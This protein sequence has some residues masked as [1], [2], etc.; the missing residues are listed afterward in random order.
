VLPNAELF[1]KDVA[2]P[3]NDG[4]G[5]TRRGGTS[6]HSH[7]EMLVKKMILAAV[8][9]ALATSS[10]NAAGTARHGFGNPRSP[11]VMQRGL[12]AIG[13]YKHVQCLW[14]VR[15]RSIGCTGWIG[16]TPISPLFEPTGRGYQR[17]TATNLNIFGIKV[18][19]HDRCPRELRCY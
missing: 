14:E 2:T 12:T 16:R 7:R 18:L 10:A 13:T 1:R 5:D 11:R 19:R 17:V 9:A 6:V 4:Q 3:I 15:P 8:I